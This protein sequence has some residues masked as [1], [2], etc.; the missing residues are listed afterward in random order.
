MEIRRSY[1][2]LISTI[3]FLILVRWIFILN[4]GPELP[5]FVF[6]PNALPFELP[7]PDI[8]FPIFWNPGAGFNGIDIFVCR[9]R[10][11]VFDLKKDVLEKCSIFLDK[12][13]LDPA[14]TWTFGFLPNAVELSEPD[15]SYPISCMRVSLSLYIYYIICRQVSSWW[16]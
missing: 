9:P 14:G 16:Y 7:E 2:R 4:Q 1:D 15:I 8:S 3:V 12:K 11:F 6:V 13:C 5:S 10:V